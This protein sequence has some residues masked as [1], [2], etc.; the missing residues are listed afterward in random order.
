[1]KEKPMIMIYHFIA[2]TIDFKMILNV[3]EILLSYTANVLTIKTMDFDHVPNPGI[4]SMT[5]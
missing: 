3:F 5:F 2:S 4:V 1:V